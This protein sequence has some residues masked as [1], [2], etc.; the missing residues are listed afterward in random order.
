MVSQQNQFANLEI[1]KD[2][3]TTRPPGEIIH[4]AAMIKLFN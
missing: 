4:R 2:V 3:A 1:P